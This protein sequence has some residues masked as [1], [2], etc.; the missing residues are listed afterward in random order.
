[1]DVPKKNYL[2]KWCRSDYFRLEFKKTSIQTILREY[3]LLD[4]RPPLELLLF[5]FNSSFHLGDAS[6]LGLVYLSLRKNYKEE[7]T[8]LQ[9]IFLER[10]KQFKR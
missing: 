10:M 6:T 2:C 1:M 5:Y 3:L 4:S 7:A 8:L 9:E